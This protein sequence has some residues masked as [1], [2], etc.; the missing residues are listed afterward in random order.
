M[1][2]SLTNALAG[3][4]LSLTTLKALLDNSFDSILIT[5]STKAGKILY[6]N[7]GFKALT[8]YLP[9][10]VVGKTPR[11]LQGSATDKKVLDRLRKSLTEGKPFEGRAINYK[12]NGTPFIMHWR[13][14]P[15]NV[16]KNTKVW[17]AIQREGSAVE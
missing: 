9:K 3:G 8:G 12:K 15:V 13:V 7:K 6:A 16:G 10:E 17:I 5:D 1:A 2:D 14:V 11:I 4:N